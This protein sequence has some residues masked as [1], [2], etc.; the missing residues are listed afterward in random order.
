MIDQEGEPMTTQAESRKSELPIEVT[1]A[2]HATGQDAAAAT[3]SGEDRTPIFELGGL[4]VFY[5]SFRAVRDV[6]MT[7]H[8]NRNHRSD[9]A[10]RLWQIDSP[11]LL[12]P[13]ERPDRVS[14]RRGP[15]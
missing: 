10:F 3:E 15:G 8:Q 11:P 7:I 12:Q 4:T 2:D 13:D 9:R 6:D 5:G 1:L 14:P